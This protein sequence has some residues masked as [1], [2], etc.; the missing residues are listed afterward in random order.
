MSY[1]SLP[2]IEE[3][4]LRETIRVSGSNIA[5]KFSTREIAAA[6]GVSE[7]VIFSH[8]KSKENLIAQAD[9]IV[10]GE[11]YEYCKKIAALHPNDF[12]VFFDEILTFEIHRP[13]ANA[14]ALNYCRV[15]PQAETPA[16]YSS[17]KQGVME[18]LSLLFPYYPL[19][20]EKK[21]F[22]LWCDFVREFVVYSQMFIEGRLEDTPKNRHLVCTLIERGLSDFLKK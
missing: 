1:R 4:I 10:A 19:K 16:D 12:P 17:F 5:N 15:F 3:R 13:K 22:F 20:D 9:T 8:F 7:F 2:N 18:T 11:F 6:A 21:A 14:F